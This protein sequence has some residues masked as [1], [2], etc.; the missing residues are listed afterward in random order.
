MFTPISRI[1]WRDSKSVLLFIP[2]FPANSSGFPVAIIDINVSIRCTLSM[3]L[4]RDM[5]TRFRNTAYQIYE[6]VPTPCHETIK[7]LNYCKKK[8]WFPI[9]F[10]NNYLIFIINH[11]VIRLSAD[12]T[13]RLSGRKVYYHISGLYSYV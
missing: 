11:P 5:T 6:L 9:L 10:K 13:S 8:G 7:I 2:I 3:Y 4:I 12:D 1:S